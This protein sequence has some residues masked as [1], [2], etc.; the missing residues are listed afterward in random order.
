MRRSLHL[1]VVAVLAVLAASARVDAK[2]TERTLTPRAVSAT[3]ATPTDEWTR[4]VE[5]GAPAFVVDGAAATAWTAPLAGKRGAPVLALGV[6]RVEHVTKLKLRVRAADAKAGAARA[7]DVVVTAFP[8][9]ATA[10]AAL[11]DKDGWQ[12]VELAQ[13][14][15]PLERV[16]LGVTSAYAMPPAAAPAKKPPAVVIG[17]ADVEL[18]VTA[19]A[20]DDRAYEAEHDAAWKAWRA[21]RAAAAKA[22]APMIYAHYEVGVADWKPPAARGLAAMLAAAEA[23]KPLA[24]PLKWAI[25]AAKQALASDAAL[26]HVRLAPT[27]ATREPAG[28]G[29]QVPSV[30]DVVDDNLDPA[31]FRTPIGGARA[32]LLGA[33]LAVTDVKDGL[34]YA[35]WDRETGPCK[36]PETAWVMRADA[37]DATLPQVVRVLVIG[38]CVAI[39]ERGGKPVPRRVRELYVYDPD[40]RAA[41]VVGESHV[42]GLLWSLDHARHVIRGAH[43]LVAP[44]GKMIDAIKADEDDRED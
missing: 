20:P 1:A 21:A 40:K 43:A 41:L 8:S 22:K 32:I 6:A 4:Y 28:D 2:P 39:A 5:R 7:K 26:V 24:Q 17:I 11:A 12:D 13:P 36:A 14:D 19:D 34:T 33:E 23:D 29:V 10:K 25:V 38:R 16:T 35:A 44:A 37:S 15:G 3:V 27:T 42:E 18:R 30:R 31:A 9:G